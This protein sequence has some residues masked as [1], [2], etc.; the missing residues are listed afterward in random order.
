MHVLTG[1][2][3]TETQSHIISI[4]FVYSKVVGIIESAIEL[5]KVTTEGK[6]PCRSKK[7]ENPIELTRES[8]AATMTKIVC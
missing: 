3:K 8:N 2:I 1:R 7:S 6:W 5:K 4:L